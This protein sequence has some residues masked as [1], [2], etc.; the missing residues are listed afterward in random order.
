VLDGIS[1]EPVG[2]RSGIDTN[3]EEPETSGPANG[4]EQTSREGGQGSNGAAAAPSGSEEP[5]QMS[6]EEQ[7]AQANWTAAIMKVDEL[8]PKSYKDYIRALKT[9]KVRQRSK[10]IH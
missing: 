1:A 8:K 7:L 5:K 6:H 2:M 3:Q 10:S 4:N 9:Y